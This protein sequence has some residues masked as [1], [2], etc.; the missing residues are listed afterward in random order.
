MSRW[1]KPNQL[2]DWPITALQGTSHFWARSC[3]IPQSRKHAY[4][5][6]I[7]LRS[8]RDCCARGFF[9]GAGAARDL[10][11][12]QLSRDFTA[13]KNYTTR[14]LIPPATRVNQIMIDLWLVEKVLEKNCSGTRLACVAG[15]WRERESGNKAR[16]REHD[17][18][19]SCTHSLLRNDPNRDG[20]FRRLRF[21]LPSEKTWERF[22]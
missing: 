6:I 21:S 15:V 17:S 20:C 4:Q 1:S 18:D 14:L 9:L 5:Q 2:L 16:S 3:N 22:K 10:T 8:W 7:N 11:C 19:P 12:S 13:K